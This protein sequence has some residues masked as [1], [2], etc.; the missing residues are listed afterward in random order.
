MKNIRR[1]AIVLSFL[2]VIAHVGCMSTDSPARGGL[3]GVI[4]DSS[5]NS[6]SGVKVATT[7]GSTLSDV[8]GK[9][10]LG[11][12]SSQLTQVTASRERYQNQTK[13]VEVLSGETLAEINFVMAA[14]S[15][16]YDI[17]VS[18]I[19][20]TKARVVFYT[21]KESRGHIR[22]G[23]N[24]LLNTYSPEDTQTGFL[25]QYELS[26]LTPASTY[27]FKCVALDSLGRTIESEVKNFTTEYTVRGNPPTN[28]K[29]TKPK[30]SNSI[31]LEWSS[32]SSV[33]FAGYKLY[34]TESS[35]GVYVQVGSGIIN[36]SFY[37]DMEV[38]PGKKYY[39]RVSRVSGSGDETPQ[40]EAISFLMP[41]RM[42]QN[43]VWTA[44]N[45]PYLLTGDLSIAPGVS[46]VIDKGVSIGVSKG[47]QWDADSDTDLVDILVQGT[48]MIQGTGDLPVTMT[49]ISPSPQAGDWNGITFDIVSDL[50]TSLI[51]GLRLSCAVDGVK[52]LA[53][54]P[55][56]KESRFFSCK[57]SGIQSK[58]G[59][60]PIVIQNVEFDT[61]ASGI[62]I[63]D[64]PT[65][66]KIYGCNLQ[67]CIYGIV[68]RGNQSAEITRNVVSFAG[69]S[70]MD[71]GNTE[72]SSITSLNVVGYGSNGT[73]ILCRGND[74]IRRNTIQTN[75]GIELKETASAK[76]R[77]N[78]ILAQDSRSSIGVLYSGSSNYSTASNTFQNNMIWDIP[79]ANTRRYSN[80]DGTALPGISSDLRF[81]PSLTGGDPFGE[82]PT[83]SFSYVPSPGS[84]LKG[85]GYDSEDV[86]ALDVPD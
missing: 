74:E 11:D 20:S 48:L 21:K 52:G 34:K 23:L 28:L 37:A 68:C 30:D 17:Q 7:E 69:V 51:K 59:R 24:G 73:G 58:A 82:F 78:L 44:Q 29:A 53:G 1:I 15:E 39:Y 14:D 43:A 65:S 67:R 13:T 42:N 41:G 9:W 85:G 77:S 70:G 50:N 32:D 84:A 63:N 62:L 8:N 16:V 25:H 6:L 45:S 47:D 12:L 66:V 4:S 81:D 72:T 40:S 54:V 10:S 3:S 86:G 5:G 61:C 75:I 56:I 80:S 60:Q 19:T 27:R 76:V 35:G 38:L 46:L 64:N 49:S 22:Y 18:S 57:Q 79:T 26:N 33:D 71:L 36:N 55:E 83:L 2:I 31:K